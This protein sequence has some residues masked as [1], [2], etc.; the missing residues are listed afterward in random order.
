MDDHD[1]LLH[2]HIILA[3][4]AWCSLAKAVTKPLCKLI[5]VIKD[6]QVQQVI[7]FHCSMLA[8]KAWG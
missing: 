3:A 1:P 6:L 8:D 4:H 5:L 2:G 7:Q